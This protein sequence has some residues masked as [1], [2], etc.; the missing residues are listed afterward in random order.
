M[1]EPGSDDIEA[2]VR[3][4]LDETGMP[5][6]VIPCD[7]DYAD[8]AAFCERYGY[9]PEVSANTI[10][11]ASKSEP[12]DYAACVVLATYRLDVNHTIRKRMSVKKVSFADADETAV[13]TGMAIGGVTPLA[14]PSHL[15]IW[16]D[17]AVMKCDE[18]ILGGGSRSLKVKVAPQIF[19][20]LPQAE[21][22]EGLAN[23]P[24]SG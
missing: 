13:L 7:P 8:T 5:Y 3:R 16:V 22:V 11:V 14:L 18:I 17:A 15:A 2:R 23:I 9:A 20:A 10:V 21:V 6:E 1:S 24:V 12:R 19:D 4:T